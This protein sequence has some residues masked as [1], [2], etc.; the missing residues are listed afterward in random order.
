M[1]LWQLHDKSTFSHRPRISQLHRASCDKEYHSSG[2]FSH[3]TVLW[4]FYSN[5][6]QGPLIP[7]NEPIFR[8]KW[9][10]N[11]FLYVPKQSGYV[12]IDS[13]LAL[14]APFF[15]DSIT[16]IKQIL[17]MDTGS[18]TYDGGI[19]ILLPNFT[20]RID[21]VRL[22]SKGLT[23]KLYPPEI[24]KKAR[25]IAK[26]FTEQ[27][28][29]EN[30]RQLDI[31]FDE[32]AKTVDVGYIP[33]H[34]YIYLISEKGELLDF[35]RV[36]PYWET[37]PSD[38][39]YDI[40]EEQVRNMIRQGENE[41]VE[42]KQE[43]RIDK[44][45]NEFIETVVA[46]ANTEGGTILIGVDDEGNIVGLN[47]EEVGKIPERVNNL[48][49][50]RCEPPIPHKIQKIS[51]DECVI[52][53]VQIDKGKDVPYFFIGRGFYVRHGSSDMVATRAE[54]E[55]IYA[56]KFQSIRAY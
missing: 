27:I 36:Y 55:R 41:R 44:A 33:N 24:S 14:D 49:A 8:L 6:Y 10:S 37:L 53:M 42:F 16:A 52:Y 31:Q 54:M 12:R 56:T 15:P 4:I 20:V 9:P 29:K 38:I 39:V 45:K 23:V 26:V 46:F 17:N 48:L 18:K 7:S 1:E 25:L 51:I 3:C 2:R 40:P 32:D 47:D 5:P 13:L 30:A 50:S 34:F 22:S 43:L 19:V 21:E 35:R 28:G 11:H